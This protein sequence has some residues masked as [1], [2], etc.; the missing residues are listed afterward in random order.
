MRLPS[1][2]Q[3]ASPKRWW[4]SVTLTRLEPSTAIT[5]RFWKPLRSEANTTREPSEVTAGSQSRAGLLV[6]LTGLE[7]SSS[8]T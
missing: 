7:P 2:D 4:V 1:G 3:E 8:I 5:Q 6:R